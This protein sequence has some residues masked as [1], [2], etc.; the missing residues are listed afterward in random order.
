MMRK[1][2]GREALGTVLSMAFFIWAAFI[3]P[4]EAQAAGKSEF[5]GKTVRIF[6]GYPPGGGHD[7]EAR[8]IA[9]HVGKYIPGN[10]NIMVQNMP[11]AGG[12]IMLAY[13]Y[14]RSKPDGLSWG[15]GSS[16]HYLRATLGVELK[17]DL[18]KMAA[19]WG[20]GGAHVDIVR[21]FLKVKTGKDLLKVDPAEI[22]V[23]GR[24]RTGSSCTRARLALKLL[25]IRGYKK[26]CAYPGTALIRAAMERGEA[27]FF[28]ATDA[29]MVG[30]GA[31]V[32]MAKRGLIAPV[33]QDGLVT[34]E[35]KIVRSATVRGDIPTFY[36]TYREIRGDLPSGIMWKA[37]K[38][39]ALDLSKLLRTYYLAPGTSQNRVNTLRK[40]VNRMEK[41][42]A[43]VADWEKIF[44]QKL[45][46][47]LVPVKE[48]ERLANEFLRPAPWQEFVRKLVE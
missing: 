24:E 36:E 48:A 15:I 11:G 18:T 20:V 32:D 41:D 47:V 44:G 19:I 8:V 30:S 27:S 7:L 17:F 29:H 21:D 22:V 46:P 3:L 2:L 42:P 34:A 37:Y 28:N 43:F 39:V 5:A 40:A 25:G 1:R 33:W 12:M 35:G 31:F 9:R 45:A 26:V 10:P 14:N 6:V 23:A 13:L 4:S 16:S 38:A